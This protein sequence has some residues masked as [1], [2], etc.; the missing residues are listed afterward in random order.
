MTINISTT[1]ALQLNQISRQSTLILMSIIMTKWGVSIKDI[2]IY[3]T[4]MFVSYTVSFFWITAFLQGILTHY[5]S[6][7]ESEKQSYVFNIFLIFN[8]LSILIFLILYLFPQ[9]SLFILTAK[10]D[11]QYFNIFTLYLL[12]FLP[13]FMLESV[14]AV[15]DRPLS[16]LIVS[17][18][19]NVL[20]LFCVIYPIHQNRDFLGCF[21]I[22][23]IV[24]LL[25]YI[26]LIFN[27]IHR[28]NFTFSIKIIKDFLKITTPLMGY[29]FVGGFITAFTT[30]LI[31]WYYV[32][33]FEQFAIY[34]FG[35]REFPIINAM[36][37]G[38]S[39]GLIPIL[40]KKFD[41]VN[42]KNA[43][44]T[45]FQAI[46]TEG[47]T[48][49][50]EKTLRL[51]HILFPLSIVLML[52]S[53][54]L[55]GL[56]FNEQMIKAAPVFQVFLLLLISRALFPQTLLMA[57][58][59][60]KIMFWMSIIEGL[61]VVIM[62]FTFIYLFGMIGVAWALVLGFLIEKAMMVLFL[63]KNYNINFKD[64]THVN[65][66]LFYTFALLVSYFISI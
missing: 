60:T 5:P 2:G 56:V 4:F 1:T 37:T 29:A 9:Q 58:K 64:Y 62:S 51:W 44:K 63:K 48:V 26:I 7:S 20:L 42:V 24:A 13:P 14:W 32:N 43:T 10:S 65:Y 16:I 19:T 36:T 8:T 21:Y 41:E 47:V 35:A 59:E 33:S 34:R 66:Y 50:K 6:V 30:W 3:E 52:F 25:R 15:E 28:G 57:L 31:S 17:I 40:I 22:M 38:L 27:V 11:T 53:K 61:C 46:N 18:I 49:L 23:V 39:S 12:F 54:P 55:F 45:S